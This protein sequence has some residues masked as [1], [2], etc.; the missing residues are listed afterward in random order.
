MKLA[1]QL[2]LGFLFFLG[3]SCQ[4]KKEKAALIT[5]Q[6][7]ANKATQIITEAIQ[8][9]GGDLYK[10]ASYRFNFRGKEYSFTNNNDEYKY[11]VKST[12]EN[13]QTLDILENG[14][15]SRQKNQEL[16]TINTDESAKKGS[17]LNSVIYFALLP[18]KLNDMAVNKLYKGAVTIHN[19]TYDAIQVTFNEEGGG[20]DHQDVFYYW[21]NQTT[22]TMDFLA[23]KY[24]VN[25]GGIRFR[26][27]Y[28]PRNVEGILFQNY[29]N[30][31]APKNTSM[32]VL[33]EL[34]E[35]GQLEEVSKI[36]I[37]NITKLSHP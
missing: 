37:D 4:P 16:V 27:A 35:K 14:E 25:G 1:I 13:Q 26:S 33:P 21:I 5:N 29:I 30:Y 9:H 15:F 22:K 19:Q 3:S 28:N 23:Y 17:A 10:K 36:E 6:K 31:K 2:S 34:F 8:K 20:E 11:T 24:E 12:S 32:D 7:T 18:Y